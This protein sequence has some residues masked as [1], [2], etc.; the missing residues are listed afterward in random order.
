MGRAERSGRGRPGTLSGQSRNATP[1]PPL[2]P[3]VFQ[4][5]LADASPS[6]P[7][8]LNEEG[9]SI[10]K[11]RVGGHVVIQGFAS[12]SRTTSDSESRL[13]T[14]SE[15]KAAPAKQDARTP[16]TAFNESDDSADSDMNWEEVDFKGKALTEDSMDESGELQLVLENNNQ[17]AKTSITRRR[18]PVTSA[19]RRLR[20]EIHRMHILA[21]LA[22]VH[23]RNH[24]CNDIEVQVY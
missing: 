12:P 7:T 5:M 13:D 21:L 15:H 23:L 10:K 4:E 3:E 22:H 17:S 20:L 11:R 14:A 6:S 19:D 2:V 8:L 24:W 1:L 18:R 9:R 16:Q